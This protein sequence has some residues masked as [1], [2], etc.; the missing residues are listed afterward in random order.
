[1]LAIRSQKNSLEIFEFKEDEMRRLKK[2]ITNLNG[3]FLKSRVPIDDFARIWMYQKKL[4]KK[5]QANEYGY[6]LC[7][8][9]ETI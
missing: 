2:C 9:I 7:P 1:M 5:L 3:N 6:I 8:L 4:L